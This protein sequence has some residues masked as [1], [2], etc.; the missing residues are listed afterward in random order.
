MNNPVTYA[1]VGAIGGFLIGYGVSEV[2]RVPVTLTETACRAGTHIVGG[3]IAD[4]FFNPED[5]TE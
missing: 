4:H 1:I 3:A 5:A 2:R